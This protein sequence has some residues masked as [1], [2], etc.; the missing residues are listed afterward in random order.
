MGLTAIGK[1]FFQIFIQKTVDKCQRFKTAD[2]LS[3][4]CLIEVESK[5]LLLNIIFVQFSDL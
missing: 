3:D 4:S 5:G 1:T 2:T